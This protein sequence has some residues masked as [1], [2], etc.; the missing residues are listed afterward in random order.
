MAVCIVCGLDATEDSTTVDLYDG[1]SSVCHAT[2]FTCSRCSAGL[3]RT[4][5]QIGLINKKLFC[6]RHY[7]S[8]FETSDGT[9]LKELRQLK[10]KCL[11]YAVARR[12]SSTAFQ[13][14]VPVEACSCHR[15]H[16]IRHVHGYWIECWER[17]DN[18][19]GNKPNGQRSE[20]EFHPTSYE[21]EIYGKHFYGSD[22]SNHYTDDSELGPLVL[23]LKLEAH[24]SREYF[25]ILVRTSMGISH[26]LL[27]VGY[28]V[29]NRYDRD[30]VIQA[31]SQEIGVNPPLRLAQLS[32]MS[33]PDELLKL[34][35]VFVKSELKVGVVYIK[36]GQTTE[37]EILNNPHHSAYFD[38]FLDIL[39]MRVKMK[40]FNGYKGGLDAIN[41]L[42]GSTSV[43][44]RW[45]DIEIMFHVSTLL[46]CDERDPQKLQRKRHIGNDIVCVVFL[47]GA[48]AEFAGNTIK[49][50]FLHTF[51]VVKL[52]SKQ[53]MRF[54]VSVV[55]R[56]EVPSFN[57]PLS[58]GHIFEKGPRF[59]EWLLCKIVNGER[60]SYTAPKFARMQDRTRLQ[61]LEELVGGFNEY[62]ESLH[63]RDWRK[64]QSRRGS[65]LPISY[66]RPPPPLGDIT[67]D[68]FEGHDQLSKDFAIA[69]RSNKL[70]DI[71]FIVGK[72]QAKLHG[73]RAVLA[74]RSRVFQEMLYGR[75][76]VSTSPIAAPIVSSAPNSPVT[77]KTFVKTSTRKYNSQHDL[78]KRAS[79][80]GSK[81]DDSPTNT[82]SVHSFPSLH[83]LNSDKT[84]S[85]AATSLFNPE[86]NKLHKNQFL[87]ADFESDVF[88][89]L[90]D[91]LHTGT[92]SI[93][94]ETLPGLMCAAEYYEVPDL[95]QACFD[96]STH[97]ITTQT[98]CT[99]F[100]Q[101]ERYLSYESARELLQNILSR[102]TIL[103]EELL[104][105]PDFTK[106]PMSIM[107]HIMSRDIQVDEITKFNAL[108]K[109]AKAYSQRYKISKIGIM[110]NMAE[111]IKFHR[112]KP[113]DLVKIVVPSKCVPNEKIILSLTYQIDP[114][115]VSDMQ[116][117]LEGNDSD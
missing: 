73:V 81:N 24:E 28:L 55:S 20:T 97:L 27:P 30:D 66:C 37:E 74:V 62:L 12:K 22:H 44:T 23:S 1:R 46:P 26:G 112:I 108:L 110:N 99:I 15:A 58:E 100:L 111:Y 68:R 92:C 95:V 80:E 70:C 41:D 63:A 79:S 77:K 39:G 115:S 38:E 72:E 69:F 114:H 64:L 85:S 82:A 9:Y 21:Q 53:P 36:E 2:C 31:I 104:I 75:V 87:V 42:T 89:V 16:N 43:Y 107:Q 13:I 101:L 51:I 91:Y 94:S 93:N 59:R 88:S 17:G 35:Q 52:V 14:Q 65:W 105:Q 57:P 25:R 8:A 56:D 45:K 116:Q 67:K 83:N 10:A 113:S 86:K 34:D 109:W 40:G 106:M 96:L 98:V 32:F 84:K 90:L 50:H 76:A 5:Y 4:T 47:E 33:T 78:L 103:T 61:M 11:G 6:E 7:N 71:T 49:S 102:Q 29:A 48:N 60:V 19:P 117:A 18:D 54:A 3:T